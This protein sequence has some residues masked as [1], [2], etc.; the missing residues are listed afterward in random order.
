MPQERRE[1]QDVAK[2]VE[3]PFRQRVDKKE[4]PYTSLIASW[5]K[6]REGEQIYNLAQFFSIENLRQAY[7][8]IDGTKAIGS[9]GITKEGYGENLE[10]NLQNLHRRMRRMAYRPASARIVLIPKP[11]GSKRSIAISNF[12]DK[13]VQEVMANILTAIYDREFKRFSF[14]F[15][16]KRS[17][18]S[19]I[20]YLYNRL[21]RR[22]LPWVVDIDLENF[23]GSVD[24]KRMWDILSNRIGDITLLRYV[25]RMLRSG[26]FVE[27]VSQ[28]AEKGTPQGSIASPVLANI[29]LHHV[30]DEWFEQ[31]VRP[32]TKGEIVRYA[33][34]VVAAFATEGEAREFVKRMEERLK[35]FGLSLN[36]NKTRIVNFDRNSADRE[37]F[38]FLGFTFYWGEAGVIH[39]VTLKVKTSMKTLKKKIQEVICWIKAN[40]SRYRL[41]LLWEK[42]A[43]KLQGHYNYFGVCWNKGRLRHFYF[44]VIWNLFRWLNRRSQKI[45]YTWEGFQ[46]RLKAKPLPFPMESRKLI[47]L[48]NP[49]LYCVT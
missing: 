7:A 9:D 42:V 48:K 46:M 14:G 28:K 41:D 1:T 19:A 37:T 6:T 31:K 39:R 4:V 47:D 36:R 25:Y 5:A 16:P 45:S 27:G 26:I 17:C 43:Q 35:E 40:R 20:S 3:T 21:R 24:H 15:R 33:D 34:D 38:D 13:L 32:E 23:F 22:N 2:L 11:D 12:E 8:E 44:Q 29:Y 49:R 18:H 10:E 30:L